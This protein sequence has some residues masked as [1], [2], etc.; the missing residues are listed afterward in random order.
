MRKPFSQRGIPRI[1][2]WEIHLANKK[3]E[4]KHEMSM[5]CQSPIRVI[6]NSGEFHLAIEKQ[7]INA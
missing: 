6:I 5:I 3:Q 1:R 7:N 2:D 4:Y